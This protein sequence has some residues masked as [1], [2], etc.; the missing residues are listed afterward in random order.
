MAAGEVV[1]AATAIC[2]FDPRDFH[3]YTA[4]LSM[5]LA[6]NLLQAW[7]GVETW[8]SKAMSEAALSDRD[9]AQVGPADAETEKELDERVERLERHTKWTLSARRGLGVL[10]ATLIYGTTFIVPPTAEVTLLGM[11]GIAA[12]GF[13]MPLYYLVII[14]TNQVRSRL[15][16]RWVNK[17]TREAAA[18]AREDQAS[19]KKRLLSE[20]QRRPSVPVG[21]SSAGRP[22]AAPLYLGPTYAKRRAAAVR[23]HLEA[24][25]QHVA[26][27]FLSFSEI[28]DLL[29]ARLPDE[30]RRDHDWWRPHDVWTGPR[31][32]LLGFP[33]QSRVHFCRRNERRPR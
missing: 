16:S 2:W 19:A 7:E 15:I 31:W 4:F 22:G 20:A 33:G 5:A 29:G 12:L 9:L 23:S 14:G 13:G 27:V 17:M 3:S 10:L 32:L 28:E 21:G 26:N 11:A 25:P 24:R 6:V 1:E 30:A 8:L 18:K